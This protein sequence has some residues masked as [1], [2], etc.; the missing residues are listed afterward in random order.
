MTKRIY[1]TLYTIFLVMAVAAQEVSV[2][3]PHTVEVGKPFVIEYILNSSNMDDFSEGELPNGMEV[4]GGPY[5]SSQSSFQIINGHTTSSSRTTVQYRLVA[6]RP[7]SFSFTPFRAVVGHRTVSTSGFHITA[8]GSGQQSGSSQSGGQNIDKQQK[9]GDGKISSDDLFIKVIPSKNNVKEQE[10]VLL[11]YKVYARNG[12]NLT[13]LQENLPDLKGFLTLKIPQPDQRE[14]HIEN[15]NGKAY[16]VYTWSEYVMYPLMTGELEIPEISFNGIVLEK[17]QSQD[18]YDVFFNGGTGTV[19][20]KVS[21]KAPKAVIKVSPLDDKPAGFSGGVGKFNIS[22]QIDAKEVK[23][24]TPINLR[25]I[26]GGSGN[27]KLLKQPQVKMG[28]D[29]DVYDAKVTDKTRLTRSGLDGNMIFD[30]TIVPKKEGKYTIPAVKFKYYDPSAGTYKTLT[31]TDYPITVTPGDGVTVNDDNQTSADKDIS[32]IKKG[33]ANRCNKEDFFFNTFTYWAV[34]VLIFLVFAMLIY[35]FR[36]RAMMRVNE[37]WVQGKNAEKQARKR[38]VAAESLMTAATADQFYDEVSKT[39]WEYISLKLNIPT[40]ELSV[41]NVTEKLAKRN[42][43]TET[44]TNYVDAIQDCDFERYSPGDKTGNM[45]KTLDNSL[46]A[47]Q[48]MDEELT[49]H[50]RMGIIDTVV[51]ALIMTFSL[52]AMPAGAV[53]KEN[54]DT[55]Y[56]NGN[57]RQAV[58]DYEEL[59]KKDASPEL[60]YNLG[61]AYYRLDNITS[62]VLSYERALRLKPNDKD[63]W[64][65]LEMANDK[66]IDKIT[67]ENRMFFLKWYNSLS[68]MFGMDGWAWCSI[69]M[70]ALSLL[71]FLVYLFAERNSMCSMGKYCSV[72]FIL[73]FIF[74]LIFA[75]RQQDRINSRDEAIISAPSTVVKETPNENGKEKFLLHEGT[76]VKIIDSGMSEWK[77]IRIADGRT[78]WINVSKMEII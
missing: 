2:R 69:V 60:Y 67:P 38:L 33:K 71:S 25:V 34:I 41:D 23:A 75:F 1:I 52:S 15:K 10:P 17:S 39:L 31:G 74:S 21:I 24:G 6:T 49:H 3:A 12:V 78:G 30:I 63:I 56:E 68:M 51:L 76:K 53:T 47:I 13:S 46:S 37:G 50:D 16:K 28:E 36:R 70:I 9:R 77:E 40:S 29:F 27:L 5:V 32:P 14:G 8:T 59:L 44:I 22:S 64:H 57:Y 62:A 72:I 11:T 20:V 43:S 19:E 35:M 26:I 66:T 55:E 4:V 48:R 58:R 42:M 65:N 45:K 54:A 73:L 18:P 7:G 61:N